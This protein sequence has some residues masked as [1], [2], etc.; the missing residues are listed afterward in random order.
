MN[1]KTRIAGMLAAAAVTAALLF[2]SCASFG[3]VAAKATPDEK[4]I[5][6]GTTAWNEK[7]PAAARPYWAEIK[8][9]S[10]RETYTGYVDAF[11]DS[12]DGDT[13]RKACRR[14]RSG[15]ADDL[16]LYC[17]ILEQNPEAFDYMKAV[18]IS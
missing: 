8:D 15:L 1:R 9:K 17:T 14:I 18:I 13:K 2:A 10:A 6:R 16:R 3:G 4:A 11:S 5:A 12:L 7:G